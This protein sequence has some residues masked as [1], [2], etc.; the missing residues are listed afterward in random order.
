MQHTVT[1]VASLL[2]LYSTPPR[3]HYEYESSRCEEFVNG[4]YN[5]ND[6]RILQVADGGDG[7]Q[8]R[9]AANILIS[10]WQEADKGWASRLGVGREVNNSSFKK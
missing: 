3:R 9:V 8:A 6:W 4:L 7:L 5:T 10:Q 1:F 2:L